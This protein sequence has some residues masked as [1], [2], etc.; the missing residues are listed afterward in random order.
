MGGWCRAAL[1]ALPIG[2]GQRPADGSRTHSTFDLCSSLKRDLSTGNDEY[3]RMAMECPRK[4][5]RAF[6]SQIDPAIL[7][8]RDGRLRNTRQFGK[9][10]LAQFLEFA[11]DAHGLTD[12]NFNS[13]LRD[14]NPSCHD[15]V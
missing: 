11:Q 15:L 13:F 4:C 1:S 7:D 2:Q 5:F 12:G 3:G 14:E 8:C 6:H 10:T 9:L